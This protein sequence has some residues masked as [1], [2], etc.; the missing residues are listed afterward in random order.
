MNESKPS[1]GFETNSPLD[2]AFN[3]AAHAVEWSPHAEITELDFDQDIN[4]LPVKEYQL[5]ISGE[6]VRKLVDVSDAEIDARLVYTAPIRYPDDETTEYAYLTLEAVAHLP[7]NVSQRSIYAVTQA[8]EIGAQ[9]A[10][11]SI[12]P[13]VSYER[14]GRVIELY[15]RPK[16]DADESPETIREKVEIALSQRR[17]I[18]SEELRE[19]IEV[20]TRFAEDRRR[21]FDA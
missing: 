7:S 2:S 15:E 1:F 10:E 9:E 20:I 6:S 8:R 17:S 11:Y 14:D 19:L 21:G 16:L 3:D 18:T 12:E 5:P 4:Q 13:Q